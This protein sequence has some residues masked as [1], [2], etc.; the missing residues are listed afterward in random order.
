MSM[1]PLDTPTRLAGYSAGV[2]IYP[3]T[4][5]EVFARERGLMPPGFRWS[6][7]YRN[8]ANRKLFRPVDNIPILLQAKMGIRELRRLRTVF[9]IMRLASPRFVLEKLGRIFHGRSLGSYFR[10]VG[11]GL[12]SRARPDSG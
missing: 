9:V 3:G 4:Q 2:R 10:I 8:E 1:F 6:A 12:V 11:Q 7:P 5:V